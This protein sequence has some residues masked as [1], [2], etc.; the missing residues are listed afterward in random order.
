MTVL[1][2]VMVALNVGGVITGDRG[3]S[4]G[5]SASI[6]SANSGVK[7][8]LWTWCWCGSWIR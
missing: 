2:V 5:G 6:G 8:L 3:V 1:A 7:W 4:G